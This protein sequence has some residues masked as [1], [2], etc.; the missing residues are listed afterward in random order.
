M[1]YLKLLS[2]FVLPFMMSTNGFAGEDVGIA[3][4]GSETSREISAQISDERIECTSGDLCQE[5]FDKLFPAADD[6]ASYRGEVSAHF[7]Y[8]D[9]SRSEAVTFAFGFVEV[10]GSIYRALIQSGD[11]DGQLVWVDPKANR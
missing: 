4:A 7:I 6:Q 2:F 10:D 5:T 8:S 9:A 11:V 1:K 3:F